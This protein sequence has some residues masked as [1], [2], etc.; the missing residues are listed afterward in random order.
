M[1]ITAAFQ[2]NPTQQS[3]TI[4]ATHNGAAG[5]SLTITN[6]QIL[7]A[8][9]ANCPLRTLFEQEYA[10]QAVARAQILN[11]EGVQLENDPFSRG[12]D[13]II[14]PRDSVATGPWGVD[15][16]VDVDNLPTLILTGIAGAASICGYRLEYR[17]SAT[18]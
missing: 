13:V 1:T 4:I 16:D 15:V 2:N 17:H 7:A 10:S 11:G 14:T 6:A 3:V 5:N 9:P 12:I 18:R 8:L